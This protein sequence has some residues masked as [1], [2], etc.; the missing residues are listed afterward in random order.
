MEVLNVLISIVSLILACH[1]ELNSI[2][3]GVMSKVEFF[4][5]LLHVYFLSE[6]GKSEYVARF[7]SFAAN[8]FITN[9]SSK[10]WSLESSRNSS[11]FSSKL[12]WSFTMRLGPAIVTPY[13]KGI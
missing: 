1:D 7:T 11:H 8:M 2:E 3:R 12:K 13:L 5:F 9:F 10:C 6:I 4:M